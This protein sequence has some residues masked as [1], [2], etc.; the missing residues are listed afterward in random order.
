VQDGFEG[1]HG[2]L[3]DDRIAAF[4]LHTAASLPT[5]SKFNADQPKNRGRFAIRDE[6]AEYSLGICEKYRFSR[7]SP[8]LAAAHRVCDFVQAE[9]VPHALGS[10]EQESS[11]DLPAI[12]PEQPIRIDASDETRTFT[13]GEGFDSTA[14][15]RGQF[16]PALTQS[17]SRNDPLAV[18]SFDNAPANPP[19]GPRLRHGPGVSSL[20]FAPKEGM[21]AG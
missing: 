1:K 17:R 11:P 14:K 13:H 12:E 20:P 7:K 9:T 18:Q 2:M 10:A 5:S 8:Q 4:A 21:I 19:D 15:Q 16:V 6:L 3:L